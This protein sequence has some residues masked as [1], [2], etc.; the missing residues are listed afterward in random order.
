MTN[1][2]KEGGGTWRTRKQKIRE[3][4]LSSL[5][6]ADSDSVTASTPASRGAAVTPAVSDLDPSAWGVT[7]ATPSSATPATATTSPVTPSAPLAPTTLAVST[8]SNSAVSMAWM[9][10]PVGFVEHNMMKSIVEPNGS[11]VPG[12]P[13]RVLASLQ[14]LAIGRSEPIEAVVLQIAEFFLEAED[15][16]AEGT[17]LDALT[18]YCKHYSPPGVTA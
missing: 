16:R 12:L 6:I 13:P 17:L 4:F 14:A 1:E 8:S 2:T 7:P 5:R 10:T 9:V 15:E 11:L 18:F 3:Q